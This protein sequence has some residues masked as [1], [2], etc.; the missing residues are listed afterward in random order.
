LVA[1]RQCSGCGHAGE[2]TRRLGLRGELARCAS[3][4]GALARGRQRRRAR[5][6]TVALLAQPAHPRLPYT[7]TVDPGSF[8]DGN[9]AGAWPGPSWAH[10]RWAASSMVLEFGRSCS[11]LFWACFKWCWPSFLK[12]RKKCMCGDL[13][14]CDVIVLHHFAVCTMFGYVFLY[15]SPTYIQIII[16]TCRIC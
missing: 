9:P 4:E 10:F 3:E 13:Q 15:S 16:N 2:G 14:S 12:K 1:S 5:G 6:L 7:Y 11:L 8:L